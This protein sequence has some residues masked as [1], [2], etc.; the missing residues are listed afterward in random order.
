MG[1][2]LLKENE[3]EVINCHPS[4]LMILSHFIITFFTIFLWTPILLYI[5]L[6]RSTTRYIITNQRVIKE[7]GILSKSSKESPLDK[8]NNVSHH[9]S[10]FGRIFNY[11]NV[12]LQ[13]ASEMGA[14]VFKFFPNPNQCK[15]E[16]VNQVDLFKKEEVQNQA[17]IMAQA[18]RGS[19]TNTVADNDLKTCPFCAE[20]IKMEAKICR[21]CKRALE[22]SVK[23]ME[24]PPKQS[25]SD[26][27]KKGIAFYKSGNLEKAIEALNKAIDLDPKQISALFNRGILHKKLG[28]INKAIADF[29][30]AAKLGHPKAQKLL[31]EKGIF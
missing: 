2:Y 16:I 19:E 9:Q 10:F 12:Q 28:D 25:A 13:T 18:M 21:Y 4:W 15:S 7:F 5:I 17:K 31:K 26:W 3:A 14:T 6:V 8:I 30:A 11:G 1:T 23:E 27:V 29:K 20:K 22:A 24:K